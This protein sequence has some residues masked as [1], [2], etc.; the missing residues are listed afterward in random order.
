MAITRRQFV[1]SL[2]AFAA[3]AGLSQVESSKLME[4]LA[5]NQAVHPGDIYMGTNGKP[6]VVW[7]HGAECTGCST[8]LLS[9]FE[10][11]AG[12]AVFGTT[13]DTATAA[14]DASILPVRNGLNTSGTDFTLAHNG[15]SPDV[16]GS[17]DFADLAID[18]VDLLY[19][20]TVMGMGGDTAYQWLVDFQANY[21]GPTGQHYPF[22]LVVGGALQ[23]TA[24]KGAWKD[25]DGGVPWCS[26]AHA[27]APL[28]GDIVPA[29]IVQILGEK[30]TCVGIVA[31]GQCAS[32]GGYPGC[33]PP[34]NQA[35]AGFD[36]SKSQTDA[37]GVWAFLDHAS[38]P[39]ADKVINVPGCPTNP[40]WFV[41]SVVLFLVDLPGVALSGTVGHKG[42]LGTLVKVAPNANNL[43][44]VGINPAA[45]DGDRRL[46][47]VYGVSVHSTSCPR[48]RHYTNGVFA[49]YPGDSG[50][51]QKIGCKGM[52][53][54]SLCGIHG[55]NA[56]QPTNNSSWAHGL[57]VANPGPISGSQGGHCTRA[58]HPCMGCTEHGYPDNFVP[59][60]VR[61]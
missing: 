10:D 39:A 8:S 23:A 27:D 48:F 34:I 45:V 55:W 58:G 57:A 5:F 38:S 61:S 17:I 59:F 41:L 2:S 43:L 11:T 14:I 26:V 3:A 15:M 4:A 47:M 9:I 36:S 50:C 44:G 12:N 7:L 32:F 19:H 40:W 28:G 21:D 35:V 22:V 25:D 24:N 60:V 37:M 6:R 31:L 42:T 16:A 49:K 53:T 1:T 54:S 52:A 33:K 29:E 56:Q 13:I 46:K 18:I 30:D 51:L 20:E